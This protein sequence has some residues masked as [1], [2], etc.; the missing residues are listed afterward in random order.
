MKVAGNRLSTPRGIVIFY[1]SIAIL[2]FITF[3]TFK[4]EFE[5]ATM[6]FSKNMKR[7]KAQHFCLKVIILTYNR[8]DALKTCLKS[9]DEADYDEDRVDVEVWIDRSKE[10]VIDNKT[11]HVASDFRWRHGTFTVHAHAVHVGIFGQWLST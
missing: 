11:Y 5:F 3:I 2:A 6:L 9:L 7:I 10:K 1:I 8:A 4:F